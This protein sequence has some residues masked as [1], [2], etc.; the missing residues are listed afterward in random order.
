MN[1][2]PDKIAFVINKQAITWA[3]HQR[4]LTACGGDRLLAGKIFYRAYIKKAN[5]V[6]AWVIGGI[7]PN[8]YAWAACADEFDRP[9][10]VMD[11]IR[12]T[13]WKEGPQTVGDIILGAAAAA[14]TSKEN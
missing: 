7:K 10:L 12:K 1:A 2:N 13:I 4:V 9:S 3:S 6:M 8:G 5:N 11:W 14:I